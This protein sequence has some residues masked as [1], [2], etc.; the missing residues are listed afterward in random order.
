MKKKLLI[1]MVTV[2]LFFSEQINAQCAPSSSV[3]TTITTSPNTCAGNG[4][5]TATFS[6]AVNTTIQLFKGGNIQQSVAN[7]T[8]PYKFSNLQP[9]NDYE[10]RTICS[11]NN[12]IVYSSNTNITV[13][14]NYTPIADA[15]ITQSNVCTNFTKGGTFTVNNVT[16]GTAPYQY[17]VILN[18]N[19]GYSDALSNYSTNNI[20]SV[21][22]FG[23]YQIRIKDNCG[24]TKTFTRTL[25]SSLPAF[26]FYFKPRK[27]CDD[28][29]GIPKIEADLW[30]ASTP[31]PSTVIPPASF[32]PLG[33]KLLIRDTNASGAIL[34]N[35]SYTGTPFTMIKSPSGTYHIT[36]TNSCGLTSSFAINYSSTIY[37][38]VLDIIPIIRSQ[39]CGASET[40]RISSNSALDYFWTFPIN[41]TV[42]NSSN[43]VVYNTNYTT[44]TGSWITPSLPV[45]NYTVTYT[46]ACGETRTTNVNNPTTNGAPAFS[47]F[48]YRSYECATIPPLT[49]NGTTQVAVQINGYLPDVNNAVV[50]IL[51]GPS[52]V[53]VNASL[54]NGQYYGWSNM[55]P[56]NYTASYTACG[57]TYTGNFTVA[58]NPAN[59]LNQSLTSNATSFCTGGGSIT[60]N[61]IYNGS[62]NAVVELIN[63]TGT[64][65]DSNFTGN[66]NNIP[67][68]TYTTR[69]K[70]D[71]C[72]GAGFYYVTGSTVTITNS[73]TGPSIS[74]AVG[75]IC[76]DASGNPLTAGTAYVDINGVAPFTLQYR[77]QGSSTWTTINNAPVSN[78]LNGLSANTLYELLLTDGC[79]GS[80]NSTVQVRTMNNTISVTNVAQPCN[81][82]SY[83]LSVPNFTDAV[84]EWKNPSGTVVSNT[85]IYS[86]A[87]YNTSYNGTYVCKITWSNCITRYIYV[88]L[89]STN[90]GQPVTPA[91]TSETSM[92]NS[93]SVVSIAS[94]GSGAQF[95]TDND[96]TGANYWET[97]G[98]NNQITIDYGK[99]Y[100]LNGFTYY[101]STSGSKVLNYTIQV[102]TDNAN[103]TD[104][105][106]GTFPNY[107]TTSHLQ[108]KGTPSTIRFASPVNA[109]YLRMI[110]PDSGKRVAEIIPIVCNQTPISVSCSTVPLISS[111]TNTTATGKK[112]VRNLDNN[113]TVTQFN[114]GTANPATSTFNYNSIT[115]SVFYPAVVVGRAVITPGNPNSTW[116][117]SPYGNA[118][119]ISAT[120]NGMDINGTDVTTPPSGQAN[121]YFYKFK[122][123]I[124]DPLLVSSLKLRLDYYADNQIV[125][126]YVNGID[127]NISTS[128]PL[129][130]AN[131]HEKSALLDKNFQTGTNE[132]V[133]QTFSTPHFAG[134][135]VQGIPSCYCL[136]DPMTTGTGIDTKHGITLLKRAGAENGNWPMIRKSAYTVLESNSKGFVPTR[137]TTDGLSNITNP[138]EGMMVFDTT[139]KCLKIYDGTAWKCFIT[140]TCPQ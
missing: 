12:S 40:M 138:V 114:G 64:I 104:V 43:A 10:V 44:T 50:T 58:P 63:N 22:E 61:K 83:D 5:I 99:N 76:E 95:V 140:P 93:S 46:D 77:P 27:V 9:G 130:Y 11:E 113:W 21:T 16:G 30:Y 66:F 90:C 132:I 110:V 4:S 38:E 107:N 100:T 117:T 124:S 37:P 112:E 128:D 103:F 54:L 94:S 102:S 92:L 75:I 136:K 74:S 18:N 52:N 29:T 32:L 33:I 19:P 131:G 116:A 115:N 82:A 98:T 97:N 3:T 45:G 105:A 57:N 20:I 39:G 134:L 55:L 69:M 65:I 36:T 121:T 60:S 62:Y 59:L 120:Q 137:M 84:Y 123:N 51:S 8:S 1:L 81:N 119:W 25:S 28:G 108:A 48:E 111:G 31:S 106:T 15:G 17:S 101:P 67:A 6:S 129:S 14:E 26:N 86:I 79:G 109:R 125:R 85:R 24:N 126:V 49:Q 68:G 135:L 7:P 2:S 139:A 42:R 72:N 118:E 91:C 122:F 89:N 35:G 70:I 56:G 87:N 73:S 71:Y 47:I 23:T 127:Q 133:V 13:A 78:T 41:V 96:V 80:V 53:G 88:T 34:Y